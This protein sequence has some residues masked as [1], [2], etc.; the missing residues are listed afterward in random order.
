M[1]V[2]EFGEFHPMIIFLYFVAIIGFSMFLMNPVCLA[3]SF[4]FGLACSAVFGGRRTA[5]SNLRMFIPLIAVSALFN[6]IFSHK[7]V[8]VLGYLPSGNPLT[9]ES[10][11]YGAAAAVMLADVLFWFSCFNIIMTSEKLLYILGRLTPTLSLV[12]SMSLRFVPK[13]GRDLKNLIE[14]QRGIGRDVSRGGFVEKI[15]NMSVIFS[16]LI[17]RMLEDSIETADSMRGRGYGMT[18]RT[19]SMRRKLYPR[20][21]CLAAGIAVSAGYM[22]A[23]ALGGGTKYEYFPAIMPV[24]YGVYEISL[25][26]VFALL[27]ALPLIIGLWEEIKWKRIKSEI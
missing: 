12:L 1:T 18:K 27:A 7:G 11:V 9:F 3:L 2:R 26:A 22:L 25:Y 21:I 6:T 5:L 16:A 8:T 24:K 19:F 23:G 13:L 10:I 4:G 17:S 14:V 20:D 15:K